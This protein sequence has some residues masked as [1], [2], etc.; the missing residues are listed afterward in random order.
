[1]ELIAGT[2]ILAL[3]HQTGTSIS[4]L[5]RHYSKLVSTLKAAQ[6]A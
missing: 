5:E 2:D 6:L 1:M 4:M 3:A